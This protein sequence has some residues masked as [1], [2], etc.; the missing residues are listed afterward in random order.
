MSLNPGL[1]ET[2]MTDQFD[3]SFMPTKMTTAGEVA[4]AG[5]KNPGGKSQVVPGFMNNLLNL[6]I[7]FFLTRDL[8]AFIFSRIMKKSLELRRNKKVQPD[9]LKSGALASGLKS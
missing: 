5:I 2:E 7:K 4:R 3:F 1:T 6:I 9:W 8:G